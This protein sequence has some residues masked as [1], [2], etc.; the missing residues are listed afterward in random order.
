MI[1][2]CF[3]E[4]VY[5][6]V[7]HIPIGRVA[8]YGEIA[9][10]AGMPNY[11]RRVGRAMA[12]APEGVPCHRVVGSGGR[13]VPGWEAQRGLLAAEGV[14]FRPNGCTDMARHRWTDELYADPER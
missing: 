5:D 3:D 10:L 7:R 12:C 6:I 1:P 2:D 9:R 14:A 11:A 13:L 4:E 8:T